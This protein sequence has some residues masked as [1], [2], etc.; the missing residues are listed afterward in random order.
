M[1]AYQPIACI[2]HERLEFAVLRHQLLVL[3]LKDG[4][5][6]SGHARDV[7]TREGAEWLRFEARD[8]SE[9]TL[10]LDEISRFGQAT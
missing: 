6:L 2:D 3:H 10:R 8:G 9:H 5:E 7:Y 1:S 4:S